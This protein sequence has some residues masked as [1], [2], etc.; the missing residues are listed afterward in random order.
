M[1]KI[2]LRWIEDDKLGLE[3]QVGAVIIHQRDHLR[4][5]QWNTLIMTADELRGLAR[6]LNRKPKR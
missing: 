2:D 3:V 5:Q 1:G 6:A 4:P